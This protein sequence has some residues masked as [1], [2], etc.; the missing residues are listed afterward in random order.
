MKSCPATSASRYIVYGD[1]DAGIGDTRN[2]ARLTHD[3]LRSVT[4][5]YQDYEA[6]IFLGDYAYE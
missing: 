1:Y 2:P 4:D 3:Y 5:N 6:F